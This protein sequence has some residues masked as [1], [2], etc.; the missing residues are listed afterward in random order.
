MAAVRK[1]GKYERHDLTDEFLLNQLCKYVKYLHLNT[2]ARQLGIR[3]EDYD[4]ITAPNTFAKD[5]Q[6]LK[7]DDFVFCFFLIEIKFSEAA[8]SKYQVAK[9]SPG[10]SVRSL[11]SLGR[12]SANLRKGHKSVKRL[13]IP[14]KRLQIL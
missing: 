14:E 5:E 6:I 13:R 3:Q 4:R 10:G 11:H 2:F 12:E 8:E 7:V 1:K 9:V